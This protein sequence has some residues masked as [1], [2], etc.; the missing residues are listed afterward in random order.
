MTRISRAISNTV[1]FSPSRA[2][3]TFPHMDLASGG[4][5]EGGTFTVAANGDDGWVTA[6]S[7]NYGSSISSYHSINTSANYVNTGALIDDDDGITDYYLA[8]FRFTNI[9]VSQGATIS[10]AY[11][12]LAHSGGTNNGTW[13]IAALDD[14]NASAPTSASDMTISGW[15][16]ASVDQSN[17][18]RDSGGSF[19]SA[20]DIFT[21]TDIKTVI[22]E[23]V[24]IGSWAS[25]NAIVIC[26]GRTSGSPYNLSQKKT[27]EGSAPAQLIINV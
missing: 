5:A 1:S 16:T 25:G 27:L 9:N 18:N 11:L 4:G 10:S 12:K 14:A 8:F 19:F 15:T 20:G 21:S 22:Q 24:D 3:E 2:I 6:K 17:I 13:R 26:M 7:T 23:I